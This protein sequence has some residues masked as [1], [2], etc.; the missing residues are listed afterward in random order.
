[1]DSILEL[2]E[3]KND[4]IKAQKVEIAE[5]TKQFNNLIFLVKYADNEKKQTLLKDLDYLNT[6]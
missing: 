4:M 2:I 3:I 5:L 1:M 6:D